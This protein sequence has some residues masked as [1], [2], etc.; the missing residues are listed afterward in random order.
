MTSDEELVE[1]LREVDEVRRRTRAAVHPA[2]FPMLLFG[3]LGLVSIPFGFI[4]SGLATGLFWLVAGPAGGVATSRYYR[5]RAMT[6]GAAVRSRA[7]FPLGLAIF[8]AAWVSGLA[9]ASAAG[10]ML[11]VA[12]GYV[13]FARLERSAAIAVVAVLLGAAAIV[14]AVT[15]PAHGDVILTLVFG[16]AFTGTGLLLLRTRRV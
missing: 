16:V 4:G 14:V 1:T 7:Y 3:M 15:D 2:W 12:A 8:V 11:A 5:R 6:L 9:T 13:A 10:P